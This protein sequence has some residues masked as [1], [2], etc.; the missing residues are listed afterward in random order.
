MRIEIGPRVAND[1]DAHQWLDRILYK[2]DDGWHVWDTTDQV[3][4]EMEATTWIRDRGAQGEWV[5]TML[6]ASIQRAA[7]T[8]A[9]HERS[10]RVTAAPSTPAELTPEDAFRLA[11]EPLWILV[12][13]RISDGAFV[14]RVVK[15]LDQS[16]RTLW[17]QP[18]TP[19]RID[20]VGGEG[21]M[22]REVERRTQGMPYRP[23]FVAV[24]D[25][26][27]NAPAAAPSTEAGRLR[28]TCARLNLPCWIL[29]K[30][31]AENY[32]PRI[33]LSARQDVGADHERLVDAWD[34]LTDD[35]KNFLDMKHGLPTPL[36]EVEQKLFDGLSSADRAILSN[37]FGPNVHAC[38]SLWN[39]PAKTDLVIRGQ[40]D[41]EQGIDLIRGEV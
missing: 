20:S 37:G 15:E 28:R 30:R 7:W 3:S 1:P 32:L 8:L 6:V 21:Q 2:I 41:L 25:S 40:G 16:L 22:P 35:Q 9:P 26:D 38:W 36:S 13:N 39:V 11:D 12:E 24:I 23:R 17:N 14:E 19:V 29:A 5:R 31:E 18:G 33:L 34:R 27:R 4:D 10:V